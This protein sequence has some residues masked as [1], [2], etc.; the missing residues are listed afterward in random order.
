VISIAPTHIHFAVSIP[1]A[2]GSDYKIINSFLKKSETVI[3]KHVNDKYLHKK[4]V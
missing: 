3:E 2:T 1:K 4:G